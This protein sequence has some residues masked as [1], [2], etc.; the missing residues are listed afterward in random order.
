MALNCCRIL[1]SICPKWENV[2]WRK[3]DLPIKNK[4]TQRCW[5][6]K[7]KIMANSCWSLHIFALRDSLALQVSNAVLSVD[8]NTNIC[9]CN[10][11]LLSL[12]PWKKRTRSF[13]KFQL[14]LKYIYYMVSESI[15]VNSMFSLLQAVPHAFSLLPIKTVFSFLYL[16]TSLYFNF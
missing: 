5:E 15:V 12:T 1:L 4:L 13:A 14:T 2:P 6:G 3:C 10:N 16:L 8:R 7:E 9:I 11:N